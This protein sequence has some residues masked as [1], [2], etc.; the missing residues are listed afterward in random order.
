M[1][2]TLMLRYPG[3]YVIM[4]DLSPEE[5]SVKQQLHYWIRFT[6]NQHQCSLPQQSQLI[7]VGSCVD[8]IFDNQYLHKSTCSL[9]EG[10]VQKLVKIQLFTGFVTLDCCKFARD[11]FNDLTTLLHSCCNVLLNNADTFSYYHHILHAFLKNLV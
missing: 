4:V 11:S 6:E 9:H 3:V 10:I 2:H 5:E 1:L 7:L 8:K